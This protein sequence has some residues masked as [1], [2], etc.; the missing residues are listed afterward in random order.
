MPDYTRNKV[1]SKLYQSQQSTSPPKKTPFLLF[2]ILSLMVII[3]GYFFYKKA[4]PPLKKLS[5]FRFQSIIYASTLHVTEADILKITHIS[6]GS[7]IF[8]VDLTA[9]K[10]QIRHHPWV[11][12]VRIS[13]CLPDR[14]RIEV[15]E[16][17]PVALLSSDRLYFM[18]RRGYTIAAISGVKETLNFPILSGIASIERKKIIKAFHLIRYYEKN[19]FL[20]QWGISEISWTENGF[21]FFTKYPAFEVRLGQRFY[22]KK[23]ARLEQ[24][25]K[26]LSQKE[27]I[28]SIVDLNFSKKVVVKVSK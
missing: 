11:R 7:N 4:L 9:L 3:G 19:E 27:I 1:P 23:M 26:D 13:R 21:G 25:L 5:V 2:F 15:E 22:R 20:K 17:K 6:V 8:D 12:K 16:K 28:P 24:V 10:N 18:D 14:L